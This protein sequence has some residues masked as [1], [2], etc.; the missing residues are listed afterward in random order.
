MDH[1]ELKETFKINPIEIVGSIQE[2]LRD[3]VKKFLK[4]EPNGLIYVMADAGIYVKPKE[5]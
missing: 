4:E 3:Y 1:K 2:T 5:K